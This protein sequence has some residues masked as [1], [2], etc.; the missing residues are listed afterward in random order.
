MLPA[1]PPDW[2]APWRGALLFVLPLP[3]LLAAVIALARGR[4]ELLLVDAGGLTA[5]ILAG[6]LLRR[7]WRS[8]QQMWSRRFVRLPLVSLRTLA[9]VLTAL[10]TALVAVLAVGHGIVTGIA[11][12]GVA[13]LGF[14]LAY[15]MFPPQRALGIDTSERRAQAVAEALAEAERQLIE[16]EQA[17]TGLVNAELCARLERIITEGRAILELIAERPGDL[18]RARKFLHVYLDGVRQ[19][20]AGYARTHGR[21]ESR[22]LE[23]NFRAVLVTVED[24]FR[25]QRQRLVQTDLMDLDVRIEVLR[26]QLEHEGIT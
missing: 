22:E 16:I 12:A 15:G 3:L 10:A 23:Q 9:G 18:Y 25:E 13:L 14:Q 8:E 7:A 2:V 17:R 1:P 11:F 24:S 21:A 20:T 6:V 4:L 19:V 5:F 26:Q